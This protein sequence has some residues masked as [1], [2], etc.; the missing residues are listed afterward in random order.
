VSLLTV[1]VYFPGLSGD[2]MFDD[3]ANLLQNRQLE[4]ETLDLET[5]QNAAFSSGSGALRRPVSMASFAL[6]RYFF[7]IAP[8]SHKVVN[9]GIHLLT[10]AALF[11]LGRM[12]LLSYRQYRAPGLSQQVVTWL[13][14]V[15]AGLWLVHPLN[16]TTVLYIVQRMT[17]LAALFTVCGLL[18]YVKGRRRMLAGRHGLSLIL[19]GLLV[20]GGLAVFSKE[21][22]ILLP[23]YMLVLEVTLFR[24]RAASGRFDATIGSFYLLV[25]AIPAAVATFYLATHAEIYLNYDGRD[26][27][28]QERLLTQ[29]RVLLFY[30]QMIVTPSIQELGLYHDDIPVSLGLLEPPATLYSLIALAGMLLAALAL[31]GKRPLVSLGILWFFA[32]HVLESS[33]IPLEMAHEHRNYLAD[34]GILLALGSAVAEAPLRRAGPLLKAALPAVFF[35]LF[36]YT[37]WLRSEQW[38]DN[39]NHA[40]YEALHHPESFRS[41]FAAGRIHARLALNGNNESEARAFELL[42]RARELDKTGIMSDITLIKFSFLTDRPVEAARYEDVI[43][44]LA[45]HPLSSSDISS[46]KTLAECAGDSCDIPESTMDRIFQQAL[47][48]EHPEVLTIY[49]FYRIN[50]RSDFAGG[51]SLFERALELD[52]REN[53]RW[54]NLINLLT[55]MQRFED[56]ERKLE[57]FRLVDTHRN[58]S[59]DYRILRQDLDSVREQYKN[60]EHPGETG[61]S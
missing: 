18:L 1:I 34:Y 40:V 42:E 48:T 58:N 23:L 56:A 14:L 17:S 21:N 27:N 12:L 44:K 2:Y 57:Q 8:F 55:V 24:F 45:T 9:L 25:L 53:Q 30:L 3:R 36:G 28:L 51:L 54:V 61:N 5:L 33:I 50:K 41:V 10:G 20:C 38:S 39:I 60:L 43:H 35:C 32:G 4:F 15:V 31:L 37:T 19:T 52:P 6:N 49:G 26:F 11:L 7:G 47:R 59:R 16:L 46:L 22:G 29:G 13:P